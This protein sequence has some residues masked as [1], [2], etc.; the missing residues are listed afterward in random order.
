[1]SPR[2]RPPL[3]RKPSPICFASEPPASTMVG[4]GALVQLPSPTST[5][6]GSALLGRQAVEHAG[7][8]IVARL[9]GAE[10]NDGFRFAPTRQ[11][12]RRIDEAVTD[13]KQQILGAS[14]VT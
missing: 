5:A 12:G 14:G 8:R 4:V 3:T 1:M 6:T 2:H 10:P 9:V 13:R 7:G 11:I